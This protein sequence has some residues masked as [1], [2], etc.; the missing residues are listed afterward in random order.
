MSMT[1]Y[2]RGEVKHKNTTVVAEIR[3]VNSR[4]LEV[5]VRLPK[6]QSHRESDVKDILRNKLDRGKISIS[7]SVEGYEQGRTPLIINAEAAH[8]YY[9]LLTNLK[10][11]LKM[12]D[13][14]TF[15]HLLKFSEIIQVEEKSLDDDL[16]WKLCEK[17][18]TLSLANLLKMRKQEGQELK[19]DL[20]KRIKLI[21]NKLEKI[22]Q[23]SKKRI[24][25]ERERLRER[26][27]KLLENGDKVDEKRLEQEIIFLADKLDI[28][29]ECIRLQSH[30][31]FFL[32]TM[33]DVE[34]SGRKLNFLIQEINREANTIGTK[35]ND[36]TIAHLAI[37]IKE[38]LEKI[39]EQI[40]NIE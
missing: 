25:V 4:F 23:L 2:G 20:T 11:S 38:E 5:S 29:E 40:Q 28:T 17:A 37:G 30:N 12:D 18:I 26:V 21:E 19:K 9:K 39:R 6:S 35:S 31:K 33:E 8:D 27:N 32:E 22:I 36:S 24:P 14:I 34:S 7:I 16:E 3:S 15:D 10:K 1:G 13:K